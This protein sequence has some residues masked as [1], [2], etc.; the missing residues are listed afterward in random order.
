M[1]GR[2][3]V[4]RRVHRLLG[5]LLLWSLAPLAFLYIILPPFWIVAGAVGVWRVVRP[6]ARW[7]PPRWVLNS[8]AVAVLFTVLAAGGL[9]VGPLRPLG[10]LL[11][12][13]TAI[14]VAKVNDLGAFRKALPTV[15]LVGLI[16]VVSA[17]H[18][19]I[20]PY[21]LV[22]LGVWWYV[23]MALWLMTL[24]ESTGTD[25]GR[26]RVGHVA[27]AAV[28]SAVLAVPT[29][30]VLPRLR[31][32]MVGVGLARQSG[33]S[34]SVELARRGGIAESN[35]AAMTLT[36]VDGRAIPESW[37]RLRA[38]AYDRLHGATWAPRRTGLS[39]PTLRGGLVWLAGRPRSLEGLRA[40][41]VRMAD[42]ERFLFMPPGA[43]A[44]AVDEAVV[45]DPPGGVVLRARRGPTPE[46]RVWIA[47]EPV[48]RF[49]E[50]E[51]RD[52]RLKDPDP[53]TARL[54]AEI[55]GA[56]DDPADKAQAIETTL[57]GEYAY[58][59]EG[60]FGGGRD[61]VAWFLFEGRRGHCEFFA[62]SMVVLLRHQGVPA[63]MVVGYHGGD[64]G[65]DRS[66]VVVRRSNA[67]AWV[68]AWLGAGRGW[69][70]F[71]PTPS[72]G[73]DGLKRLTAL[74]RIRL[75]WQATKDFFDRRILT[76][77]LGEQM[78]LLSGLADLGAN[79]LSRL[80]GV[81][82]RPWAVG[83]VLAVL[84]PGVLWFAVRRRGRRNRPGSE[85]PVVAAMT[86][87]LERAG[88]DVPHSA[89][90]GWIGR[91]IGARWPAAAPEAGRLASAIQEHRFG[92][93]AGAPSG[94]WAIRGRWRRLRKSL[95][96][97]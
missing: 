15:F 11:L 1:K 40:V 61:P 43:V 12:L 42:R 75:A 41:D 18:V 71:D 29:F 69:E 23:G 45:I 37:L 9:R 93:R 2:P 36:S 5:A 35:I 53:R 4:E 13:L 26:P 28:L 31:S 89:T 88:V 33:F 21:L 72:E 81:S 52:L 66:T 80:R 10:H 87:R 91:A 20:V 6:E 63:R 39:Q 30:I 60:D 92:N 57:A 14:Q 32:P 76:F 25:L 85:H 59:L 50:P 47:D 73:V 19:A 55:S 96:R 3:A 74:D 62:A 82:W 34:D 54:A 68:E 90:V 64:A 95:R 86:R 27:V 79:A 78:G 65:Q 51:D 77:G 49:G 94:P 46:Y 8:L 7:T 58:S 38:S 16:G 70:V 56:F 84:G 97:S 83:L 48:P 17:V 24:S 67:H 22:S 44:L